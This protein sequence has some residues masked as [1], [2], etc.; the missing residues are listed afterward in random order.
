MPC[1][2]T[3]LR[4]LLST[5]LCIWTGCLIALGLLLLALMLV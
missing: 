2:L 1:I 5:L 3:L 4:V